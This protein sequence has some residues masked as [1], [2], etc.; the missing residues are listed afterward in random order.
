MLDTFDL[1]SYTNAWKSYNNIL[2]TDFNLYSSLEDALQ[3]TNAWTYCNYD[4]YRVGMFGQCGPI[5]AARDQWTTQTGAGQPAS[6]YLL[7]GLCFFTLNVVTCCAMLSL[8]FLVS[9]A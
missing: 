6:F 2:G 3:D 7:P 4:E 9:S 5:Q 8:S 1:Y